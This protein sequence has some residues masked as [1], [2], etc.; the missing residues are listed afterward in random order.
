MN[1]L[2]ALGEDGALTEPRKNVDNLEPLSPWKP[3]ENQYRVQENMELLQNL[4]EY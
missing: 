3:Q 1:P 2:H 4:G